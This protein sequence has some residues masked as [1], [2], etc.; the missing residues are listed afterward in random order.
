MCPELNYNYDL[1]I[2]KKAATAAWEA[3]DYINQTGCNRLMPGK[4]VEEYS[5]IFYN[6][7]IMASDEAIFYQTKRSKSLCE[8]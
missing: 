1:E 8:S 7:D 4:T 3:I 2:C 5:K 6:K